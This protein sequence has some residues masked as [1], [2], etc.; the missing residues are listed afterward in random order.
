MIYRVLKTL[1]SYHDSILMNYFFELQLE[2]IPAGVVAL[3]ERRR[4]VARSI[5]NI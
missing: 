3:S 4:V 5:L 2:L 1:L